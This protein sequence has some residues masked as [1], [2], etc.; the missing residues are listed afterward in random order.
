MI[1]EFQLAA[2]VGAPD[3]VDAKVSRLAILGLPQQDALGPGLASH[4][5]AILVQ[6]LPVVL[7]TRLATGDR[8]VESD[9]SIQHVRALHR[10]VAVG[11]VAKVF[12]A[13]QLA[14]IKLPRVRQEELV[15]GGVDHALGHR[16]TLA[17][18]VR[19]DQV[20]QLL[21]GGIVVEFRYAVVNVVADRGSPEAVRLI[22]MIHRAFD[23]QYVDHD[24]S[25]PPHAII[26]CCGHPGSPA[27]F[28]S[29][30]DDKAFDGSVFRL[31]TVHHGLHRVHGAD[32]GFDHR[33]PRRPGGIAR[34]DVLHP[35]VRNQIVFDSLLA[36]LMKNQGL[37]RNH[38]QF[39]HHGLGRQGEAHH[40][41]VSL[42]RGRAAVAASADEHQ[43]RIIRQVLGPDDR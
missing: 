2:A 15:A 8:L 12:L 20:E 4:L 18:S 28:G 22:V 14:K 39:R 26:D 7:G 13:G 31:G 36:V 35:G 10:V 43:P 11:H 27:T 19:I 3:R 24:R 32:D 23:V 25:D 21:V 34:F 38:A 37:I 42:R 17:I 40:P 33:Q 30:G 29:A 16:V 5:E 9:Q 1:I 41:I 6:E